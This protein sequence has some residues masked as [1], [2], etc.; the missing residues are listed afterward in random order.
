[1]LWAEAV[2]M[3]GELEQM[4]ADAR[5]L[6]E[7]LASAAVTLSLGTASRH[8]PQKVS[9]VLATVKPSPE[10]TAVLVVRY[11]G[12]LDALIADCEADFPPERQG[13]RLAAAA[14]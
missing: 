11:R 12:Y 3:A 1:M 10:H 13:P 5:E 14:D 6:R 4:E 9:A 2:V 8:V 7:H